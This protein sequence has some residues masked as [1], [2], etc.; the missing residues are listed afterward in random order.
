[1][2]HL[3]RKINDD[4]AE[5]SDGAIRYIA[6]NS[7]GKQPGA[8]AVVH[9]KMVEH[10]IT[11]TEKSIEMNNRRRELA[12]LAAASGMQRAVEANSEYTPMSDFE[13]WG[14]IIEKQSELSMA[15]DM[16]H[17]STQAAKL[18][19]HAAGMLASER[20]TIQDQR[21]QTVVLVGG[22]ATGYL[23]SLGIGQLSAGDGER[24]ANEAPADDDKQVDD[25]E[26]GDDYA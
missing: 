23:S 1:M 17:A 25:S 6:G 24:I 22:D 16:G 10:T 26:Y 9:P 3:V 18:V 5:Y 21:K 8:L 15:V 12:M 11:T 4:T 19:G 7:L 13:A 20:T 14:V 2:T